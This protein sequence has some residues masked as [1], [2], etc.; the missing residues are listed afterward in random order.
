MSGDLD[1]EVSPEARLYL[2]LLKKCLTRQL[3]DDDDFDVAPHS[4]SL[5]GR[6]ARS[7]LEVLASRN[8]RLVCRGQTRVEDK[9]EGIGWPAKAETMRGSRQLEFLE[10]AV[11]RILSENVP[12]DLFEAGCWRGGAV[13]FMLGVLR[14]LR[15]TGRK[16]WAADSFA[17]YPAPTRHSYEADRFLWSQRDYFS[18]SR[19]EFEQNVARYDLISDDL[20]I[21][22]GF[23]DQSIPKAPIWRLAMIR[24]DIE[25]YEGVRAALDVLYPKLS[26]GG[27]VVVDELEVAGCNHAIDEFF[28]R[29]GRKE[30]ILPIP[31]KKP[32][33]A[34]W[35]K[36]G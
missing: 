5:K 12:G 18:V 26:P 34:Y 7:A 11:Q 13:I 27:F 22:E 33:G 8:I 31:Q 19:A 1:R 10:S 35:R 4:G 15:Q 24:I 36:S 23:F 9:I 25:G 17:G 2:D 14:A 20:R 30:E 29:T 32:K 16:V 21:L 28:A 3:F 6:V